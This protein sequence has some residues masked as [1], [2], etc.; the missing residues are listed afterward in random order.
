LRWNLGQFSQAQRGL[1]FFIKIVNV[2]LEKGGNMGEYNKAEA[3]LGPGALWWLEM[4]NTRAYF[5]RPPCYKWREN[6]RWA[7]LK[8]KIIHFIR[9]RKYPWSI[10]SHEVGKTIEDSV[11]EPY[12]GEKA[13]LK[14]YEKTFGHPPPSHPPRQAQFNLSF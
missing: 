1:D 4:A 7:K 9:C 6:G 5:V 2:D 14:E 12:F 3:K 13:L 10:L 11:L 8:K